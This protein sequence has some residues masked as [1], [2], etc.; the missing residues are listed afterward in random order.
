MPPSTPPALSDPD[1]PTPLSQP[2]ENMKKQINL[3]R[4]WPSPHLLPPSHLLS[5]STSL[6]TSPPPD[7][8]PSSKFSFNVPALQYGADPGYLPLRHSL[9][10]WLTNNYTAHETYPSHGFPTLTTAEQICI[11][12]GAS[13][14]LANILQG[15][16]DPAYTRAVWA[17]SPCYFLA[18][19]IFE[20]AGFAVGNGK[21]KGVREDEEGVDLE[22]LERG[23]LEVEGGREWPGKPVYKTPGPHRKCYKHIIYL[24]A[25]SANPSGITTSLARRHAL[26]QLARKYD[27]LIISDDVYDFLQWPVLPS[28]SSSPSSPSNPLSLPTPLPRL[29]D[30]DISLGPSLH[31]LSLSAHYTRSSPSDIPNEQEEKD[32]QPLFP[33]R[34]ISSLHFGHAV[35]NGSFSK[36]LSPGLRTGWTHSTPAFAYGLS[37]TGSTRSGGAP[38]QFCAALI[39]ELIQSGALDKH[40]S[41]VVRPGLQKRHAVMME[42]IKR[43]LVGPLGVR[44]IEDNRTGAEKEKNREGLFGGYFL[45]LELPEEMGFTAKEVAE[46]ALEEERL[47]VSPGENA[48]VSGEGVHVAKE[49][50]GGI[51]FPRHLRVCFSWEE[52]EDLVEGVQRLGRVL[53]RMMEE[54]K[55]GGKVKKAGGEGLKAFK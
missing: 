22:E 8:P 54:A 21:L 52:E 11:T 40:L 36:L 2:G 41:E 27:A 9:A 6:L 44:V 23:I 13:Q 51:R 32:M 39:H 7:E 25:T 26:V 15:F 31:D 24:V 35:S 12:G 37:Q 14:N 49:E 29:S 33:T 28:S 53:R 19:P 55:E 43:E 16:T 4:G 46:R 47:V 50:K 42:A 18:V 3:L 34:T 10:A 45:W 30:I 5:A 17:V 20:D 1:V 48:E 38:S